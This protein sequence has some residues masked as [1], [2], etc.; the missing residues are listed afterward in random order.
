MT[1]SKLK[2]IEKK[3]MVKKEKKKIW[4]EHTKNKDKANATCTFQAL[5]KLLATVPDAVSTRVS[6]I[7]ES[8]TQKS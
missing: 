4:F 8:L 2:I 6:P 7:L 3:L 1:T 5:G